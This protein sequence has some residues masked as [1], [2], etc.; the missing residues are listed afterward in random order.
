[1]HNDLT[2]DLDNKKAAILVLLDLRAAF[3][4]IDHAILLQ[5]CE[6]VFNIT[7]VALSWLASFLTGREQSV[8]V[9]GVTSEAA[10]LTSGVPQGS[11][12]GPLLFRMI[13]Y[14]NPLGEL[15]REENTLYS[16]YADDNSACRS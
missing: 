8:V 10:L 13:M 16:T 7:G 4:T 5:M 9:Y 6:E 11:I 3:G 2:L 15:L 1:M 12:L 14:T